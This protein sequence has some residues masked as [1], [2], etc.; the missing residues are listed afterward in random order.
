MPVLKKNLAPNLCNIPETL[1]NHAGWRI[2]V[3]LRRLLFG[4]SA[5]KTK[6]AKIDFAHDI[7]PILTAR[8]VECHDNGKYKAGVSLDTREDLLKFEVVLPQEQGQRTVQADHVR[9]QGRA[10]AAQGR[11]AVGQ[12]ALCT[13]AFLNAGA[14][15]SVRIISGN[16]P[17]C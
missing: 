7:V 5:E 15:N 17:P 3:D 9:R 13:W 10:H 16:R 1:V 8:C 4:Q 11:V 14:V 6:P 12:A 2:P